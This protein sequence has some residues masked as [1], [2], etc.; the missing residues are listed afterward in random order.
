MNICFHN[1]II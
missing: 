1:Y